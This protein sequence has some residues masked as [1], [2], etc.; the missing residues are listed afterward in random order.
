MKHLE[1]TGETD[2]VCDL[3]HIGLGEMTG[4]HYYDAQATARAANALDWVLGDRDLCNA[5]SFIAR[6]LL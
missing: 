3:C 4:L 2:V 6:V 5:C 1:P